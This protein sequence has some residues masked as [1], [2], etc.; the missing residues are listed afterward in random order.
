MLG[1]KLTRRKFLSVSAGAATAAAFGY[2][3]FNC[4]TYPYR[5]KGDNQGDY[6]VAV[7]GAG[8]G[9]LT[10][11]AYLAKAGFP[12]TVFEQHNIPGGYATAFRRGDYVFDVSLEATTV[13]NNILYEIFRDLGLFDKI[14]IIQLKQSHRIITP[15]RDIILPD[16]DP[17]AYVNLLSKHFHHE[18]EGIKSYVEE[19]MG[20]V[21]ETREFLLRVHKGSFDMTKFES[22]FP[23]MSRVHNKTFSEL[24]SD[25]VKDPEVKHILS[26]LC[27]YYGL[28]PSRLSGFFYAVATGGFLKNGSYYIKQRSQ[29]LSNALADIIKENGG[30]VMLERSVQQI[31]MKDGR[32]SGV[33]TSEGEVY[34]AR[35]VV[36]NAN[37]PDT[38]GKFLSS[39]KDASRY[40]KELSKYQSSISSFVVWLGLKGEIRNRIQGCSI[41]IDNEGDMETSFK[42]FLRCDAERVPLGV[43]LCDNYYG[44]YSKSG[45]ST[46]S[47][48]FLSGYRP[49]KRFEKDYFKGNKKGYYSKKEQVTKTLIRRVEEKLI[50]GLSS[51]I[52]VVESSTPL[53]NLRYTRNPEG[54]IYGYPMSVDNAFANRIPNSTPIEGL[55]LAGAWGNG[56]GSYQGAMMGGHNAFRLIIDDIQ[57][58]QRS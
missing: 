4:S 43:C 48:M 32:A 30:K 36:S 39:N 8:L 13:K 26:Y 44:G 23:K 58:N 11:A 7:I 56:G 25:H 47:I 14:E 40:L 16:T 1:R 31:I 15:E 20:I 3:S 27:G 9:G 17:E 54:A 53:T 51:M 35:I 28:P 41:S 46:M 50:P 24:L 5:L 45:T 33:R 12:V 34:P 49:W 29:N 57:Q 19:I 38:F 6:P 37:A 52:D 18:R 42:N 10:C 55:Y 22:Q 21:D 2:I